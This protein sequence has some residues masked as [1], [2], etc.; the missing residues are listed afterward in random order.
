MFPENTKVLNNPKGKPV[1]ITL[2]YI[3]KTIFNKTIF[4][5]KHLIKS[6]LKQYLPIKVRQPKYPILSLH[7]DATKTQIRPKTELERYIEL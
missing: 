2:L 1:L 4:N 7:N 5:I 6:Y 3:I